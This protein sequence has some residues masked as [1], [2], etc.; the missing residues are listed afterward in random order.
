MLRQ[1]YEDYTLERDQESQRAGLLPIPLERFQ[2]VIASNVG[3]GSA[4]TSALIKLGIEFPGERA[5]GPTYT[6]VAISFGGLAVLADPNSAVPNA[7]TAFAHVCADIDDNTSIRATFTKPS[8]LLCPWWDPVQITAPSDFYDLI[9]AGFFPLQKYGFI[10]YEA[11]VPPMHMVDD[12]GVLFAPRYDSER[13]ACSVIRWTTLASDA[14]DSTLLRYEVV[15]YEDGDVEFRYGVPQ[16]INPN[17]RRTGVAGAVGQAVVGMFFASGSNRFRDVCVPSPIGARRGYQW[18]GFA[19][20][21]TYADPFNSTPY[22]SSNDLATS[23]PGA[24]LGR[25]TYTFGCPRP[26]RDVLPRV[27]VRKQ[28]V[29]SNGST[30]FSSRRAIPARSGTLE[31]PVSLAYDDIDGTGGS[32]RG[33]FNGEL[34]SVRNRSLD[35]IRFITQAEPLP[36]APF[37]DQVIDDPQLWFASA[38]SIDT[39]VPTY[40][41]RIGSREVITI[42]KRIN[43]ATKFFPERSAVLQYC[44]AVRQ[45]A[46]VSVDAMKLASEESQRAAEDALG[47]NAV[48]HWVASGTTSPSSQSQSTLSPG[49]YG[50]AAP[51][52]AALLGTYYGGSLSL[53]NGFVGPHIAALPSL[54]DAVYAP[55]DVV[56]DEPFV[57][58][59]IEL[60]IPIVSN[61][62]WVRQFT[63]VHVNSPSAS[64]SGWNVGGPAITFAVTVDRGSQLRRY[65]DVIAT[66]SMTHVNDATLTS[67]S[68]EPLGDGTAIVSPTGMPVCGGTPAGVVN[69]TSGAFTGSVTLRMPAT[70]AA[71]SYMAVTGSTDIATFLNTLVSNSVIPKRTSAWGWS[72]AIPVHLT[73]FGRS[74]DGMR[75]SARSVIAREASCNG[76]IVNP[77]TPRGADATNLL[78]DLINLG[79]S[80]VR[81]AGAGVAVQSEESPYVLMPGDRLRIYASRGRS[82]ITGTVG[83]WSQANSDAE[84][85]PIIGIGS[86]SMR[87]HLIGRRLRDGVLVE[88]PAPQRPDIGVYG[89][90]HVLDQVEFFASDELYGTTLDSY[91]T[92][93]YTYFNGQRTLLEGSAARGVLFSKVNASASQFI[94]TSLYSIALTK[95]YEFAGF[96][97]A[98]VGTCADERYY[99]SMLPPID[100]I[101][102]LDGGAVLFQTASFYNHG[103]THAVVFFDIPTQHTASLVPYSDNI[104]SR[105]FPFEPRYSSLQRHVDVTRYYVT[106]ATINGNIIAGV[107]AARTKTISSELV[108]VRMPYT[109]ARATA[110]APAPGNLYYFFSMDAVGNNPPHVIT[111]PVTN[112]TPRPSDLIKT[113]YGIGSVNA[114]VITGSSPPMGSTCAV[115]YAGISMDPPSSHQYTFGTKPIVRGWKYGIVNG[116]AQFSRGVWRRSKFGQLRDMLEQRIDTKF[117]STDP[118]VVVGS[119]PVHVT[120]VS[121]LV[122]D[123]VDPMLTNSS[124]L[125]YEATSSLPYFDGQVRNR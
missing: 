24:I 70:A 95:P 20:D 49:L 18:G 68:I 85:G 71:G 26:L 90:D 96:A 6:T 1:L 59:A 66:G 99:D 80:R 5:G 109:D 94:D 100:S 53:N 41:M 23:W 122:G 27:E 13:G 11:F 101:V 124:N 36:I 30:L 33:L 47:F 119:S 45:F 93:A 46:Y 97:W 69:V 22:R 56:L 52:D 108:V 39:N 89:D 43:C 50:T 57:V 91:I 82:A 78:F 42:A 40:T 38:S 115:D 102:R 105:A 2:R 73:P 112:V 81:Y 14:I 19:Y 113:L 62:A 4:G 125:S 17:G 54:N 77:F 88:Q 8:L 25:A 111:A 16:E 110:V 12:G 60:D 121:A 10:P 35:D 120:F 84:I 87:M 114:I 74:H 67:W 48:G 98:N 117:A 63:Q 103:T 44:D 34:R 92:G 28:L 76:I 75:I 86:G 15:L 65:R 116:L 58:E 3:S 32:K 9:A 106:D 64:Y 104:W 72:N 118:K 37:D 29:T 107:D 21:P 61:D 83:P 51:S 123:V 55:I 31:A 7:A 79:I